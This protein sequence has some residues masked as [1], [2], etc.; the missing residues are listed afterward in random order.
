MKK[1]IIL[2]AVMLLAATA[3][4]AQH[5]IAKFMD[6]YDGAKDFTVVKMNEEMFAMLGDAMGD[7]NEE[8]DDMVK[9]IRGIMIMNYEYKSGENL[10]EKLYKEVQ[11]TVPLDEYS[12]FMTVNQ[13]DENVRFL[14]KKK[15][16]KV[17]EFLMIVREKTEFTLIWIVGEID[18]KK[19]GQ[20]GKQF[21][22]MD[23]MKGKEK[24]KDKKEKVKKG[25][26]EEN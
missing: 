10:S 15:G 5:P 8:L 13:E 24:M 4:N 3:S 19:I 16:A 26:E 23:M 25:N 21:N 14:T 18:M 12:T 7:P 11:N 20:I 22:M 1:M 17:G 9:D 2:F 6:K